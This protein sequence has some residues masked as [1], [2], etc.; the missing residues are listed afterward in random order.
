MSKYGVFSGPYF[1]VFGPNTGKYGP[2]NTPYLETLGAVL[3]KMF[4]SKKN[5]DFLTFSLKNIFKENKSQLSSLNRKNRFL[6]I[7]V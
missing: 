6:N 4:L 5:K 3:V 1:P 7:E 2:E